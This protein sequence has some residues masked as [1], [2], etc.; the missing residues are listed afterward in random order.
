MVAP[1]H[2]DLD[3]ASHGAV[4]G[5]L[6]RDM[7]ERVIASASVRRFAKGQALFRQGDPATAFFI[8]VHGW[9]KLY[10]LTVA[11]DEVVIDVLTE[12]ESLAVAVAFT[13]RR[14]PV[15]AEA[16]SNSRVLQIPV[17]HVVH[18]IGETPEIA[19]AVMAATSQRFHRLVQQVEQLKSQSGLQRVAE[20]LVSL[21]PVEAG[22]CVVALPYDK[23]SIAGR[24]GLRPESL[25]RAFARLK[26]VG[27]EVD[28]SR[29]AVSEVDTLRRLATDDR[30]MSPSGRSLRDVS[31]H[32][33]V[34]A[35]SLS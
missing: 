29:V 20:F 18:C 28:A 15:A 13:R 3:F 33:T 9:V 21:C 23:E 32:R 19:L 25:S 4:L 6:K 30:S 31:S 34:E 1:T 24:L 27:V 10:R 2:D 17:R 5:G 8:I 16:I 26:S 7:L 22:P 14:H 12:G 35:T 11:G